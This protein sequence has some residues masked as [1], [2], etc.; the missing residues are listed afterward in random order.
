[1]NKL[2][3][4]LIVDK[5]EV[6]LLESQRKVWIGMLINDNEVRML[7]TSMFIPNNKSKLGKVELASWGEH[8]YKNHKVNVFLKFEKK[9]IKLKF[10]HNNVCVVKYTCIINYV[11]CH[12]YICTKYCFELYIC[13]SQNLSY[14]KLS[15]FV[16]NE[17]N[18]RSI[19]VT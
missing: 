4:M 17:L 2:H 18:A 14:S 19:W 15:W 11:H 13:Y 5:E 12:M 6:F 1:M 8:D 9:Q 3:L 7:T 10:F 16:N